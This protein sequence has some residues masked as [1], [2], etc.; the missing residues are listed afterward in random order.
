VSGRN[1]YEAQHVI[2]QVL[3]DDCACDPG[4]FGRDQIIVTP[5]EARPN[6]RRYPVPAAPLIAITMGSGVVIA[7]HPDRLEPVQAVVA[8][9]TRDELFSA[10][11]ISRLAALIEPEHQQLH[12]PNLWFACSRD[13]FRPAR[14]SPDVEIT[15]CER[16]TIHELYGESGFT[17]ALS[18]RAD[19]PRPDMIATVARRDGRIAGIA[20]ASADCDRLWQIGVDVIPDER[21]HGIGRALVSRLTEAVLAAGRIPCYSTASSNIASRSLALRMGYWP[22][23]TELY[24]LEGD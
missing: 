18:Y 3:A 24:A 12:G 15:L 22:A 17:N 7:T 23:W 4:D 6:R 14:S 13:R 8:E 2:R 9:R 21:H 10:P 20:A 1:R 19:H 5:Y 16:E 11:M